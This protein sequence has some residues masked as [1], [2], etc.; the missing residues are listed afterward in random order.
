MAFF[1]R[2]VANL[3]DRA[4][5]EVEQLNQSTCKR[6]TGDR[7]SCMNCHD[8]HYTPDAT[9]RTEYF[10]GKCLA[11]HNQPGF[12]KTHH[13][14]NLDCTSCHMP[15]TSARNVLHVA[16]TDHRIRRLPQVNTA[17]PEPEKSEELIPIFSP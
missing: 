9:R 16:W 17:E 13:P 14:E 2:V 7:M 15:R 8:P 10:R 4:V 11:C 3:T 1:I 5:S 12:A 6:V